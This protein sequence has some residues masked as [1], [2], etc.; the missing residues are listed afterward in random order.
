MK[1]HTGISDHPEM[2]LHSDIYRVS[3]LLGLVTP[4]ICKLTLLLGA[5][6]TSSCYVRETVH[7]QGSG[8]KE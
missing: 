5:E 2:V 1:P 4:L 6:L 3:L 7:K 8:N